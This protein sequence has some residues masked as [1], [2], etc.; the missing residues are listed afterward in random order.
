MKE[1]TVIRVYVINPCTFQF[2]VV[3][4]SMAKVVI[5]KVQ[6]KRVRVVQVVVLQY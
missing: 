6:L 5:I 2:V 4:A 3:V 1:T